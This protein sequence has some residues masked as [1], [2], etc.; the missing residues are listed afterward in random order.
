MS[1]N[2][3]EV[4][5][6]TDRFILQSDLHKLDTMDMDTRTHVTRHTVTGRTEV[7]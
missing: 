1:H 2:L 3:H 4:Q 6:T 5:L 7:G